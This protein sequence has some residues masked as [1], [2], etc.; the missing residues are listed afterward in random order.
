MPTSIK[1][2]IGNIKIF[3]FIP[4]ESDIVINGFIKF[5][6]YA[7]NINII[8]ITLCRKNFSFVFKKPPASY[9]IK[10]AIK[11]EKGSQTPGRGDYVSKVTK[12]QLAQ[13]A[14]MKMS[15]LNAHNVDDACKILEGTARSMGVEVV[16]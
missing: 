10:K 3:I 7:K 11:L 5:F 16:E 12:K 6:S 9:L 14:E 13:I 8:E 1:N 15:D 2:E 4:Q